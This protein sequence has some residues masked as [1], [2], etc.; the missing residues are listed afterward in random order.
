MKFLYTQIIPTPSSL[1]FI[2]VTS[3]SSQQFP[4]CHQRCILHYRFL[5]PSHCIG[6]NR[7][8]WQYLGELVKTSAFSNL[9]PIEAIHSAVLNNISDRVWLLCSRPRQLSILNVATPANFVWKASLDGIEYASDVYYECQ[10][11]Q[12]CCQLYQSVCISSM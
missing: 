1:K 3:A 7:T 6:R 12:G 11:C 5:L 9:A 10:F 4:Y 8:S 2:R